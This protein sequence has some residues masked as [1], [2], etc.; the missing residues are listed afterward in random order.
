MET[1]AA[2]A[3]ARWPLESRGRLVHGLALVLLLAAGFPLMSVVAHAWGLD[4]QQMW[5]GDSTSF[6]LLAGFSAWRVGLVTLVGL[7][8]VGKVTPGQLGWTTDDPGPSLGLGALGGFAAVALAVG[9]AVTLGGADLTAVGNAVFG[10]STE[11]RL[12]FV[13]IAC[14][15]AFTEESLFRGYLQPAMVKRFGFGGGLLAT[16]AVFSLYHLNFTP[17]GLVS[18]LAFGLLFGLLRGRDRPLWVSGLAHAMLWV[19]VGML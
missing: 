14:D 3:A 5:S 12:M 6:L 7:N 4:P 8:V 16:S 11:Q 2:A 19:V 13:M 9:M 18:K 1:A 10:Y 15:A 17:Q